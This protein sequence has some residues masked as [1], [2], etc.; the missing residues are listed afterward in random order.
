MHQCGAGQFRL[1]SYDL[2]MGIKGEI[3]GSRKTGLPFSFLG[4]G[5]GCDTPAEAGTKRGESR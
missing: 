4:K 2:S 1:F 5:E 3:K